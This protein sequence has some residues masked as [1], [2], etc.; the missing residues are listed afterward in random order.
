MN[1]ET[2]RKQSVILRNKM[3]SRQ[4]ISPPV[5]SK[6]KVEKGVIKLDTFSS[7]KK[8][9]PSDVQ[10]QKEIIRQSEIRS[11]NNP[12]PRGCGGCRRKLGG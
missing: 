4:K 10:T 5:S 2:I 12:K 9:S 6:P 1:R 3:L 11:R 7:K 8:V